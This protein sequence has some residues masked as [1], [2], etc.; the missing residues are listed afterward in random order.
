MSKE[1]PIVTVIVPSYNHKRFITE[2]LDSIKNQ[3]YPNIQWIVVDDG[4]K[5]GTPDYLKEKQSEYG[6]ELYLQNNKGISATLTDMIKNHAKGKYIEVCASDD[7][8]LPDKTRLQV[9]YMEANPDCGMCFGRSYLMDTDSKITG[10][11]KHDTFR[12]GRIF[13]ELITIKF[14]P[15]INNMYRTSAIESVG[16][17]P[18]NVIAEDFYMNCMVSRRYSVGYIPE[19][20]GRYRIV[21][22]IGRRD[23]Y[24]L[25]KSHEQTI[26]LFRDASIYRK[27]INLQNLRCFYRL[28][29][30]KKYKFKSVKYMIKSLPLFFHFFFAIGVYNLM[31]KWYKI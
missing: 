21:P 13:E 2:C 31:F 10:E 23:P 28:A 5:D 26:K 11:L 19:I 1:L 17:Y 30:Y 24:V 12:G 18:E 4:S 22:T 8:W 20:L 6:Y 29:A 3:T 9:E 15:A 14:H 16:Y 25:L 27:A 7:S